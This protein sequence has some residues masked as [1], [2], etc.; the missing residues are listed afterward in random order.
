VNPFFL[1]ILGQR[2]GWIPD[3]DTCC[4]GERS[5]NNASGIDGSIDHNSSSSAAPPA[6]VT[7]ELVRQY[8]WV[9]GF[10][11]APVHTVCAYNCCDCFMLSVLL[12]CVCALWCGCA[13]CVHVCFAVRAV[14]VML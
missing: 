11:C 13:L 2:Y 12:V 4:R 1:G 5:G 7:E 9:P 8:N 14:V 3:S 6:V 10:R